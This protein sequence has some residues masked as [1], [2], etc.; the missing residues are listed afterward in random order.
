MWSLWHPEEKKIPSGDEGMI[1][2]FPSA[3]FVSLRCIYTSEPQGRAKHPP[4]A[5]GGRSIGAAIKHR[6]WSHQ[7]LMAEWLAPTV[8]HLHMPNAFLVNKPW[9][10]DEQPRDTSRLKGSIQ[11]SIPVAKMRRE[12]SLKLSKKEL[13]VA[14]IG[15]VKTPSASFVLRQAEYWVKLHF[16]I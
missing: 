12:R 2:G 13:I 8:C 7:S 15:S 9:L 3:C 6:G 1:Q 4:F 16:C 14:I 5:V 10:S 11:V